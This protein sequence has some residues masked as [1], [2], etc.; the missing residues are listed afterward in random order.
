[1]KDKAKPG[2]AVEIGFGKKP[3]EAEPDG[4]ESADSE[5]D[6]DGDEEKEPL[7]EG[8]EHAASALQDAVKSGTPQDVVGAFRALYTA[9]HLRQSEKG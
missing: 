7:D 8:E 4:D 9:C 3:P 6:Y 5:S 2:L 1:M